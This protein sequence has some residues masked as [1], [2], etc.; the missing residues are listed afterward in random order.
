VGSADTVPSGTCT[1]CFDRRVTA[2][3]GVCADCGALRRP[4]VALPVGTSLNARY[5]LGRV[6]GQP[7]G[8]GITYLGWDRRLR[9]RV[10][11]KEFFPRHLAARSTATGRLS[12]FSESAERDFEVSL[13]GFLAEAR[14]LAM[15]DHPNLVK[16]L[17]FQEANGTGYLMMN[18]YEGETLS[19]YA[20]R[21]GGRLPWSEL[22]VIGQELLAGLQAVHE[23]GLLHRDIKPDNVY[24]L[25]RKG[26]TPQPI[27]ID[28]G[29]ARQMAGVTTM[30]AILTEGFAPLEQ[31]PNCGPQGPYTDVYAA[32]ATFY[33][34]SIGMVPPSATARL[35]GT[36]PERPSELIPGFPEAASDALLSAMAMDPAERPRT[37]AS[38]AELLSRTESPVFVVPT[39]PADLAAATISIPDTKPIAPAR[40]PA[41]ITHRL[42]LVSA[43]LA[44]AGL[45]LIGGLGIT[46]WTLW[47]K[48]NKN[49]AASAES[50]RAS[51]PAA[52]N[53]DGAPNQPTAS[54][55]RLQPLTREQLAAVEDQI[56]KARAAL[57][58]GD[59]AGAARQAG[60]G[61]R[62][63]QRG[64]SEAEFL[65]QPDTAARRMWNRA[66]A[67]QADVVVACKAESAMISARGEKAPDCG[68]LN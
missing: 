50:A 26:K 46:G 12:A 8:F 19:A 28:F 20:E 22:S 52:P 43:G 64:A 32:A 35:H 6:L 13:S 65:A 48:V 44:L 3:A 18:Y 51:G 36:Q 24:L 49:A 27:L 60:D 59:Y 31:Y 30:T 67:L 16:V 62:A 54:P 66:K 7:G 34:V 37:A 9:R 2:G 57:E 17:D 25:P 47:S 10:A 4:D 53:A 58:A 21:R 41:S 11:I 23:A 68:R 63:L 39:R 29:A 40:T 45:L 5:D 1:S 56:K 33:A 55:G 42:P 61:A 15:L 14:R 38:F